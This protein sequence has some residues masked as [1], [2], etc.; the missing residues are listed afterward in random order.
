MLY[1]VINL[2][3]NESKWLESSEVIEIAESIPKDH[4]KVSM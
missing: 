2:V 4:N 1:I 3:K